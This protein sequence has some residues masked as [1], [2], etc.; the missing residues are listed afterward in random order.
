MRIGAIRRCG[1]SWP[2]VKTSRGKFQNCPDLFPSDIILLYDLVDWGSQ[3]EVFKDGRYGHPSV[4]KHP[5]TA[6]PIWNAFHRRALGPVEICHNKCSLVT[7]YTTV[8]C[9][10]LLKIKTGWQR[11]GQKKKGGLRTFP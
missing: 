3:F 11:P 8:S 4:A 2:C 10:D 9:D 6:T 7:G 1:H 5:L